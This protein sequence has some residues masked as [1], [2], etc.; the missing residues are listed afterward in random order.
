MP[1]LG[2]P[3]IDW[4]RA[5]RITVL[6]LPTAY[7]H[8]WARDLDRLGEVVPED[9]RLVVVGGEKAQAAAC[10]TWLRVGGGRSRWVNAYGPTEATCMATVHERP[11]GA[12]AEGASGADP[13]IGRPLPNTT[14]RLVDER[15]DEV[16]PGQVGELLIGGVG[17]ARGYLNHPQLTAERFVS[18]V[19]PDGTTSR[20]YRTGDLAR[21]GSS[22]D[23]EYVGRI[24]DQ[25][26]IRGFRV[27]CGEVEA[28]LAQHGSVTE[29][30]VVDRQD[31]SGHRRLVA[32]V[33]GG[34]TTAPAAEDLRRFLRDRLPDHMVPTSFV[35]LDAFPLTP[36]GKVDRKALRAWEPARRDEGRSSE[37]PRTGIEATLA[38][39]WC[40]V[41]G[42]DGVGLDDDFF[43]LG[44]HSLLASQVI[45]HVREELGTD[46]PLRAIFEAPTVAAL[47]SRIAEEAQRARV[48]PP[49]AQPRHPGMRFPLSLAQEQMW[50]LE[51][52]ASPPGL[53]NVTALRRFEAPVDEES[54]RASLDFLVERHET[55]R[56]AVV[57]EDG[58][59]CQVV[60][61]GVG[62]DL[63]TTD[64]RAVPPPARGDR[65]QA[66]LAEQDADP[67]DL[68]RAPLARAQLFLLDESSSQLAVTFD[69]LISD[70]TSAAIFLGE[71]TEAYA[72][73]TE[74][75]RPSLP[76]LEIQFA[77]FALWQRR[78]LTEEDL[79]TQ[80][81]WW[82]ERLSGM[83]L[84]PAVPFDRI[85]SEP[86]RRISSLSL[87]VPPESYEVIQHLARATQSSVFIVCAAA[88]SSLF[89]RHS[90]VTDVLLSTTLSGRQRAELEPMIS[91][92]AGIGRVRADLS[93]DPTFEAVVGRVRSHVLGMF[94]HQDVPFMRVRQKL[95]PDFPSGWLEVASTLPVELAYFPSPWG[96]DHHELYFRGQLHPL[97]VTLLDDGTQI[98]ATLSYKVAFY[99]EATIVR[100]AEGLQAIL[101]AVGAD[102]GLPLSHLPVRRAAPDHALS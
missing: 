53:Y 98:R 49:T 72:A 48:P 95:L 57:V 35:A 58:V 5:Q 69:H 8:E 45:A 73:F 71:L 21:M 12:S 32:Y 96:V 44:G 31:P 74:G 2:R 3:W 17:L 91:M 47:A 29:A 63:T 88:V 60:A 85:P 16:P 42:L 28:T 84:G 20:R 86:S 87:T 14:V 90:G 75:R 27:E 79:G 33:I 1:I 10:S 39:I 11:P 77:D 64:L 6:N 13:P 68:A 56:T 37:P 101:D 46:T 55:L 15:G 65:L 34:G 51:V 30:V 89:S 80:V 22:G 41:L 62:I 82:V 19:E 18:H 52:T 9:V 54:L 67:F 24:D 50:A 97:S 92:F 76:P 4:L 70:G 83:P 78:W 81:D 93:G 100:L 36:N 7:W 40:R 26:K 23:L 59:P 94:E 99:D 66:A 61:E 43:E 25:V 102:P 38:T